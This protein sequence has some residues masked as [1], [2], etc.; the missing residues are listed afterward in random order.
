MHILV[1][2]NQDSALVIIILIF[3]T[4]TP[5]ANIAVTFIS[6]Q[7]HYAV[8]LIVRVFTLGHRI[9]KVIFPY[10]T[11]LKKQITVFVKPTF[12]KSVIHKTATLS[13][14]TACLYRQ[15]IG[16]VCEIP[17]SLYYTADINMTA[18]SKHHLNGRVAVSAWVILFTRCQ[19]HCHGKHRRKSK[20]KYSHN[21]CLLLM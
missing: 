4:C 11:L 20:L 14:H 2:F 21:Y 12:Y 19:S 18:V 13:L 8:I 9:P 15:S 17:L 10:V 3:F 5:A 7:C 16:I 1:V 6:N